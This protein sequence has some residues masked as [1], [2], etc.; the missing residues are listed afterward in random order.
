MLVSWE[1]CFC[2]RMDGRTDT[3]GRIVAFHSCFAH[4]PKTYVKEAVLQDVEWVD[5]AKDGDLRDR[6][7]QKIHGNYQGGCFWKAEG[8]IAE[9]WIN[10]FELEVT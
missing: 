4:A 8:R 3:V 2:M 9:F 10:V 1:S 6:E 7:K 5:L